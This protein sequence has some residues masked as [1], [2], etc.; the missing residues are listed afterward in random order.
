STSASRCS[1]SAIASSLIDRHYT[2]ESFGARR[3]HSN[4]PEAAPSVAPR[5]RAELQD[6]F[7]LQRAPLFVRQ[8][9]RTDVFGTHNRLERGFL[10]RRLRRRRRGV[11]NLWPRR[12]GR[13]PTTAH[14]LAP[15]VAQAHD[16]ILMRLVA[17][18]R[19]WISATLPSIIKAKLA[20]L[21][22]LARFAASQRQRSPV[23]V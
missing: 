23:T 20:L 9:A 5:G 10:V 12:V 18:P 3:R 17:L 2:R 4:G 7:V 6:L 21:C 8:C 19:P 15:R 1:S 22:S 11:V 16:V 14:D 13:R